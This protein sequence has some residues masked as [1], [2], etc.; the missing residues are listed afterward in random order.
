MAM[1]LCDEEASSR[2]WRKPHDAPPARSADAPRRGDKLVRRSEFNNDDR[3]IS[4]TQRP[5][6][7]VTEY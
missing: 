2:P 1:T 7:L 3:R 5:S 4:T 6:R